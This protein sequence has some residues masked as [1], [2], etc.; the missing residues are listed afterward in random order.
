MF[1]AEFNCLKRVLVADIE[2]HASNPSEQD[3]DRGKDKSPH[4]YVH[5]IIEL[6]DDFISLVSFCT[7]MNCIIIIARPVP[8]QGRQDRTD[9]CTGPGV[10]LRTI[11]VQELGSEPTWLQLT[12][13]TQRCSRP[14]LRGN[15]KSMKSAKRTSLVAER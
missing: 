1:E 2:C 10:V 4:T 3:D 14:C 8:Q 12:C 9:Y 15:T 7:L 6:V 11:V 13:S 5:A